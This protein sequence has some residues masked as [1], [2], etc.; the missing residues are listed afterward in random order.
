LQTPPIPPSQ[1]TDRAVPP[2]LERLI[3]KCLAKSPN[4]RPQSAGHLL[5]ALELIPA[6][7]W[8]E[9]EAT[10][11]W[12]TSRAIRQSEPPSSPQY[13]ASVENPAPAF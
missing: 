6:D 12:T 5:Q 4:D 11:W 3:L 9:E 8:G 7:R 13:S 1:R 2:E 10:R